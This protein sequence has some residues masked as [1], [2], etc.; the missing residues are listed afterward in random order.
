MNT[1]K[2][3][4]RSAIKVAFIFT[5]STSGAYVILIP[6]FAPDYKTP[7]ILVMGVLTSGLINGYIGYHVAADDILPIKIGFSFCYAT[8]TIFL[9]LLA[10]L[11]IILN[12][13]GA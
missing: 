12:I 10:S 6:M 1:T 2:N 11:F 3:N 13:R 4:I 5:T 8:T 7:S 9:V